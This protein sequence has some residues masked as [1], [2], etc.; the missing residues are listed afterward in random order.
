MNAPRC[1]VILTLPA[2]LDGGSSIKNVSGALSY[3][4]IPYL[5]I[6][7]LLGLKQTFSKTG[8]LFIIR[9]IHP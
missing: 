1:D 8:N 2:L 7:C 5:V 4:E 9:C 3:T 6:L